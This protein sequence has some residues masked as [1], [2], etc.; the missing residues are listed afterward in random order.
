MIE[1]TQVTQ[2]ADFRSVHANI[3]CFRPTQWDIG[4][5]FGSIKAVEQANDGGSIEIHTDVSMSYPAAKALLVF[6]AMNIQAYEVANGAV[7][8]P[9][10]VLPAEIG[11]L[12][13]SPVADLLAGAAQM[14][15]A[16]LLEPLPPSPTIRPN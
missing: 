15:A 13:A 1:N 5:I 9:G 7:K 8:I 14:Q 16:K 3:T 4:L 2:S 10:M 11:H 6:L 12:A